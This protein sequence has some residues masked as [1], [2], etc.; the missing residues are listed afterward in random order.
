MSKPIFTLVKFIKE[1]AGYKQGQLVLLRDH[2]A[3]SLIEQE[4]AVKSY[5]TPEAEDTTQAQA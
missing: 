3:V 2:L 5:I 1:W 4:I